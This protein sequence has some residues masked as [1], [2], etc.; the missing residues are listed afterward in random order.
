LIKLRGRWIPNQLEIVSLPR[1]IIRLD[2]ENSYAEK[3]SNF[4]Q[5]FEGRVHDYG[6]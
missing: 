4:G 1:I 3:L 5:Q 6:R 2:I